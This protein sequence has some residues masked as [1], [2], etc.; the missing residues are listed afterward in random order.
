NS[1]MSVPQNGPATI[2]ASSRTR[3]PE[4]GSNGV[5]MEDGPHCS[6]RSR[7]LADR[8]RRWVET[9][10]RSRYSLVMMPGRPPV[11]RAARLVALVSLILSIAAGSGPSRAADGSAS[12]TVPFTAAGVKASLDQTLAWYQKARVAMRA[13]ND[14]AGP[15]FAREDEQAVLRALERAFDA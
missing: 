14:A 13:I 11:R 1:A 3:I 6:R 12:T 8:R 7:G 5:L 9:L 15:L 10:R 4:R 2:W